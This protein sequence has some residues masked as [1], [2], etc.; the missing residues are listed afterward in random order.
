MV[1]KAQDAEFRHLEAFGSSSSKI[2]AVHAAAEAEFDRIR[3]KENESMPPASGSRA[4]EPET[5]SSV[6]RL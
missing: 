2:V 4:I 5:K 3:N 6:F 1:G